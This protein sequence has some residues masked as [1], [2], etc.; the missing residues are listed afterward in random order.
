VA[1]NGDQV[2]AKAW[3]GETK[4]RAKP[5]PIG[6]TNAPPEK[7]AVR[8]VK[9]HTSMVEASCAAEKSVVGYAFQMGTDPAHPESWPPQAVTKGHTYKVG[10][11]PIGQIVYFRIAVI[12]RG[13]I[14]GQWSPILQIQVH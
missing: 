6:T 10:N 12:R 13:S 7:A 3:V 11:L 8:N 9:K 5:L 4:D 2:A 14:Q 1:S